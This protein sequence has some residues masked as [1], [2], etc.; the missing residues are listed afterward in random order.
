MEAGALIAEF[1]PAPLTS[2][3]LTAENSTT[4]T[5]L[6]DAYNCS[7]LLWCNRGQTGRAA[8]FLM[9]A[10]RLYLCLRKAG[11]MAAMAD[12]EVAHIEQCFTMTLFFLA[13]VYAP[14][15]RAGLAAAYCHGTLQRQL[16]FAGKVRALTRVIIFIFIFAYIVYSV[17]H[18]K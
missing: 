8:R 11:T 17:C 5:S 12:V 3:A 6:L 2:L 15:G 9:K 1:S 10:E 7:G 16:D 4:L 18:T 14:S 13:Q